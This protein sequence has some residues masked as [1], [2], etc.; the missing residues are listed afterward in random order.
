MNNLRDVI[1]KRTEKIL[2][3]HRIYVVDIQDGGNGW[4]WSKMANRPEDNPAYY[5]RFCKK[6]FRAWV[7][8]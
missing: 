3:D 4:D 6:L 2:H 1:A 8:K 7:E 5:L